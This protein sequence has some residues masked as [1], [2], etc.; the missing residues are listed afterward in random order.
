MFWLCFFFSLFVLY[1]VFNFAG[2][3]G[4]DNIEIKGDDEKDD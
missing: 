2:W 3:Y 4:D 1:L